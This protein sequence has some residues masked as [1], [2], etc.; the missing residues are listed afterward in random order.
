VNSEHVRLEP[1]DGGGHVFTVWGESIVLTDE[2]LRS[3]FILACEYPFLQRSFD[4][5]LHRALNK[6]EKRKMKASGG[7]ERLGRSGQ[8]SPSPR[9]SPAFI[10][11]RRMR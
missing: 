5:A 4:K 9:R 6:I 1:G 11:E 7:T 2:E 8:L 10:S 3:F